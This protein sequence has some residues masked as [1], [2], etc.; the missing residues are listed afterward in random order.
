MD[1]VGRFIPLS[2]A[3]LDNCEHVLEAAADAAEQLT[4]ACR[5]LH[6]VATSREPLGIEG[7]FVV[8]SDR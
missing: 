2:R 8:P 5:N 7:E 4:D 1:A 6:I 3:V